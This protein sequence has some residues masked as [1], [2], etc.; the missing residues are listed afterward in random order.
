MS[1][2]N[3]IFHLFRFNSKNWK[4]IAL[5][6]FTATIFWFFNSLNKNYTTNLTF[7][8]KFEYDEENYV[9]VKPLPTSVRINVTGIGWDLFRRSTGLKLPSLIIPL[10]RPSEVR[11]IVTV[12]ALFVNQLE[13]FEIN[14]V[15]TDTLRINLEP[16]EKRYIK[17]KLDPETIS[18]RKGFGRIS[19]PV[20]EP[21]S[22]Y[23]E[24]PWS[25]VNSFL[26]P[27]YLRLGETNIDE[28]YQEDV[29]VQFLQNEL[30]KRNPPTVSVNFDV[31]KLVE[32]N[33][34][35]PLVVIN[36]PE[37]ANPYLGIKAL[38]CTFAVPESR[39]NKYVPDSVKAV[40]DLRDFKRGSLRIKPKVT[41][42]PSYSQILS[43]DSIYVK[44]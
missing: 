35:I 19:D 41:G 31:D 33:D 5:C 14:F 15:L 38:P 26:E 25:V 8:L 11:K 43:I 16:K 29:E 28:N 44:L 34:S 7:P 22:I 23:V 21:D 10:E 30:I 20:L 42:L 24:G 6:F 4:A 37:G 27:V 40:L 13:R 17:L 2:L 32:I 36:Y 9:A 12:P 18:L 1:V 39:M 3:S